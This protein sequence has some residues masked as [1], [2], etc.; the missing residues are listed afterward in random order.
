[1]KNLLYLLLFGAL[2]FPGCKNTQQS[3]KEKDVQAIKNYLKEHNLQAKSTESGLYY[4][5]EKQGTGSFPKDSSIVTVNY[6][7]K[8]LNGKVF[9][10]GLETFPLKNLI[11]GWK[12]GLKLFKPGGKGTLFIP[13]ALAYGDKKVASIPPNSVLIFEVELIYIE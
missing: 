6:T 10:Q 12:E 5:I 7:G 2:V 1:M 3:Q 9:D 11:D 4:I 8:L 13:S